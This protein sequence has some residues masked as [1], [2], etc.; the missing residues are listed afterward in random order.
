MQKVFTGSPISTCT[1]YSLVRQS[2]K[3]FDA[4]VSFLGVC[5]ALS[6]GVVP[7]CVEDGHMRLVLSSIDCEAD[8][9]ELEGVVD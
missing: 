4:L 2:Y 3:E 9:L 8:S 6:G 7:Y 1:F 5:L